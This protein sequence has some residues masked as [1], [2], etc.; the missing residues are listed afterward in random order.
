MMVIQ[1]IP[2]PP[3][4]VLPPL[5]VLP[6][7]AE[8]LPTLQTWAAMFHPMFALPMKPFIPGTRDH[9]KPS[10]P[11]C[12]KQSIARVMLAEPSQLP[13]QETMMMRP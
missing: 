3:S 10:C 13:W 6:N 4:I 9:H 8:K 12:K 1:V 7:Q 5:Q 2:P 11:G